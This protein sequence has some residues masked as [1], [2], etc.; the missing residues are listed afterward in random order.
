MWGEVGY[1]GT[2][3]M[4]ACFLLSTYLYQVCDLSAVFRFFIYKLSICY[5]P[6]GSKE[7]DMTE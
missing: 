7:S 1:R 2:G 3:Q 6:W 5:S 4:G